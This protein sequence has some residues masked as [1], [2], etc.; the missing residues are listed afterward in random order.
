MKGLQAAGL[1]GP[2]L[3]S[4]ASGSPGDPD[5][6]RPGTG[7]SR[8]PDVRPLLEIVTGGTFREERFY[9]RVM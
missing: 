2:G 9:S 5:E 4:K 1:E 8:V 7:R 6:L 3:G